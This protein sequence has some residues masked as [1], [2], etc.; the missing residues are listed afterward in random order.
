VHVQILS[1]LWE[2]DDNI[3]QLI[4]QNKISIIVNTPT[5]L[6]KH[7]NTD[8]FRIRRLAVESKVPC[9]TSLDTVNAL[10]EAIK[11]NKEEKDLIPVDIAAI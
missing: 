6:S 1:K 4:M 11:D 2:G 9:F 8:G 10:W 5:T 3:M 7:S